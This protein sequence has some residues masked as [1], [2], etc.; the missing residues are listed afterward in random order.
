MT[1]RLA[2]DQSEQ[3]PSPSE[4]KILLRHVSSTLN[5]LSFTKGYTPAQWVY[6]KQPELK[7]QLSNDGFSFGVHSAVDEDDDDP[8]VEQLKIRN[9]ARI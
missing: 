9:Q 2:A 6:G 7:D 4:L 1:E 3:P 8:F 5:Q